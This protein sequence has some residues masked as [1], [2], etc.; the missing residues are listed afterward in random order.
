VA[1]R[2]RAAILTTIRCLCS[3]IAWRIR[4]G[5]S[6]SLPFCRTVPAA[7]SANL[8]QFALKAAYRLKVL[9][10]VSLLTQ[11]W[12]AM[13]EAVAERLDRRYLAV[14]A[15]RTLHQ[16]RREAS[17][18]AQEGVMSDADSRR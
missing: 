2:A 1:G 14:G 17:P 9:A 15:A 12:G 5:A 13:R 10:A 8:S 16:R 4:H 7:S 18:V 3:I 6:P 11:V